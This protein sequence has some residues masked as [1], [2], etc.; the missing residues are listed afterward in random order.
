MLQMRRT[1]E[2]GGDGRWYSPNRDLANNWKFLAGAALD[3]LSIANWKPWFKEYF[4]HAKVTEEDIGAAALAYARF[5]QHTC[6]PAVATAREAMEKAGWF[7]LKPGAQVAMFMKMGQVTTM[8]MFTAIR[9]THPDAQG[10]LADTKTLYDSALRAHFELTQSRTWV[11]W[12]R[13]KL[14]FI[15]S[16]LW[17]FRGTSPGT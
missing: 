4:E 12:V 15:R 7:D 6:D 13:R 16:Y 9:D 2:N 3:Q 10:P 14:A 5:F 8:A 1:A 17:P 11:R